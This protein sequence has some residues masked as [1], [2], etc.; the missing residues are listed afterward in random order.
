[1]QLTAIFFLKKMRHQERGFSL[2]EVI[3]ASF[4]LTVGIVTVVQLVATSYRSSEDTQDLIIAAE[5]AQEGVELV[6]NIR[7]NEV[8]RKVTDIETNGTSSIDVLGFLPNNDHTCTVDYIFTDNN[9]DGDKIDDGESLNCGGTPDSTLGF[10]GNFFYAHGAGSSGF[11]RRIKID[12]SGGANPSARIVSLVTWGNPGDIGGFES[13]PIATAIGNC[14]TA[15]KCVYTE[16]L[17][18][19]WK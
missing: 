19:A 10:D 11:Y 5:L 15:T 6:R 12:K 3:L 9:G 13:G 1:M 14:S 18:T 2:G 8:A 16:L 17:L 7:D 4:V